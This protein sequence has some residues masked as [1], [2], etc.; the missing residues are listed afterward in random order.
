MKMSLFLCRYGFLALLLG[1]MTPALAA[2]QGSPVV[3]AAADVAPPGCNE[4]MYRFLPGEYNFCQAGVDLYRGR[5]KS[6]IETLKLAAGWGSKKAQ[7]VLGVSYFRGDVVPVDHALGLA[8]LVLAMERQ[9]P[10]YEAVFVS[11]RSQSTYAEQRRARELLT[12]MRPVYADAVAARRAQTRFD[13]MIRE[14]NY[15]EPFDV[16]VCIKGLT[17]GLIAEEE[18]TDSSCPNPRLATAR[19]HIVSDVYFEGWAG[20]VSVGA[21]ESV[22]SKDLPEAPATT[23]P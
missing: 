23:E 22:L 2:P 14:L 13:R 15:H 7:Y 1:V 9:D 8:W 21:L 6:A 12:Q 20:H 19:L 10:T 4:A 18:F 11:A 17:G 3:D 16:G 5:N